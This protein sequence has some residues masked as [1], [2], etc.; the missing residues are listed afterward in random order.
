MYIY[1]H[2]IFLLRMTDTMTSQNIELSSWVTLYIQV[3]YICLLIQTSSHTRI[4]EF[5]FK[6]VMGVVSVIS[7]I[8]TF[9]HILN[10]L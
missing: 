7:D 9:I 3:Y 2:F 8:L 1:I 5:I 4:Y 6:P 10:S